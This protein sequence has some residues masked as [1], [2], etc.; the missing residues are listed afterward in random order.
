MRLWLKIG[1]VVFLYGVWPVFGLGMLPGKSDMLGI[2][3][4]QMLAGIAVLAAATVL[5]PLWVARRRGALS[6]KP[7]AR[8]I[9]LGC[10]A[11]ALAA[12]AFIA[13][14][15][16]AAFYLG[17]LP[18]AVVKLASRLAPGAV[19]GFFLWFQVVVAAALC[20]FLWRTGR[21]HTSAPSCRRRGDSLNGSS[22]PASPDGAPQCPEKPQYEPCAGS[23]GGWDHMLRPWLVISL[24]VLTAAAVFGTA[25][26]LWDLLGNDELQLLNP[27]ATLAPMYA[28]PLQFL[29]SLYATLTAV[30][31]LRMA[32]RRDRPPHARE[33][34]VVVYFLSAIAAPTFVI[35]PLLA[36]LDLGCLPPPVVGLADEWLGVGIG[37]LLAYGLALDASLAWWVKWRM[38]RPDPDAPRCHHCGYSLK[39][40]PGPRCPECGSACEGAEQPRRCGDFLIR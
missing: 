12:P 33:L 17:C 1:P 6:Q 7:D 22:T 39:G 34:R 15:L 11:G 19:C 5:I 20:W 37:W 21:F 30:S 4:L 28:F 13:L 32:H 23:G 2:R 8:L 31:V 16:L 24:A 29:G 27:P 10:F 18:V 26:C 38:G 14:P 40:A 36:A 25:Q 35:L 3:M 9:E